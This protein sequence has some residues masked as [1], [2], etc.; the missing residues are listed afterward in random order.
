M[1]PPTTAKV[2]SAAGRTQ[3]DWPGGEGAALETGE[4]TKN[5][6]EIVEMDSDIVCGDVVACAQWYGAFFA[7][8]LECRSCTPESITSHHTIALAHCICHGRGI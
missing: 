1:W 8:S 5:V 7:L 4:S 3:R 2:S 6:G